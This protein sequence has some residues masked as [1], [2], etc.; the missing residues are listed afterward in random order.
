MSMLRKTTKKIK[1][2]RTLYTKANS[3]LNIYVKQKQS[4]VRLHIA[5]SYIILRKIKC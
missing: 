2:N 3:S 1:R 5:G 4:N